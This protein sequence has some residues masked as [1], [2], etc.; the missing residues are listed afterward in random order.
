MSRLEELI[1]K[2]CPDGVEYCQLSTLADISTGSHNTNEE[3]DDGAYPFFVRSQDVRRLNT[4]DYDETAIITS[5]DG[6][7]VGKIFHYISGKYALHQRAYRIHIIDDRIMSEFFFHY[8][9][10]TFF[11]YIQ[12]TA[13]NSSVTSVRRPMLNKYPVPVPPLEVQREIVRILDNFTSLTAE[14]QA[15]L[16]AR[17]KQYE[18]YRDELLKPQEKIPMVTLGEIG[19]VRMCKRILKEQTNSIGDVPFY[20]IGTFGKKADAFIT[21]ELFEEYKKKYSY[22][23]KG[24]IL[25]SCSGTI[26]RTIIFDGKPSYFQDSNIVWLEHDETK[27]LNKYLMYCYSKQPWKIS[28]G[29]TISRL[30]NDN[31]LKAKIPAPSLNVQKRLVEVL[32]NFEKICSDLNIGLPAEIEAR[33]K[34]YEYYRDALLSFDNS[35]FVNVERERER[36]E[37]HSGLIKLWQYVFGYAPVKLKDI[38]ISIKDG[39][40]NLPKLLFDN[41]DYPILSA[42][43]IH[44]GFIDFSTKRYVDINTF[45]K[46]RRRTNIESGDV[47][48]T[49]VA[50]IG[51][52]AI[53]K[54]NT[55][56]LLQRSVCVIK[57]KRCVLPSY[58]KYYLD[59]SKT[60]AYMQSN[61]HGSA[62]A[63]LY[64]NQVAEIEIMLPT[65]KEQE[66]IV[67]ILD[68]FDSL[69]NDISSGLPAEIEA[70]QKQY[71]YYR[72]KL[73]SF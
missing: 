7:G 31:I 71:E 33:Q 67:S 61:A 35:Y 42:Q 49:I 47:L 26:G 8:M 62:Q 4:Y 40:H 55:D 51:R 10:A 28:T 60:Q 17:K 32:D 39:M 54:D 46:E 70:R 57:P 72:D 27:V 45:L 43:N 22:P 63:G 64:L 18:Y 59:T 24:D 53:I 44:N 3:L 6:V 50:T 9:K 23:E 52:T 73:L 16:Q 37:W 11:E 38:A 19:R 48:L 56:F 15:E 1:Q 12:K 20:K 25:I 58:L 66:R 34:Q 21:Q 36:D 2:L 14:L 30:Y 29:G 69:C 13:V 5:G 68:R 41:G 65:L